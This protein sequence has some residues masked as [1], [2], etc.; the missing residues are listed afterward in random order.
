MG[1]L[2]ASALCLLRFCG[3]E[4]TGVGQEVNPD[5]IKPKYRNK[6]LAAFNLAGLLSD[7]HVN[8]QGLP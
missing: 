4:T 6:L 5:Q 2:A 7:M 3:T 1:M 8:F